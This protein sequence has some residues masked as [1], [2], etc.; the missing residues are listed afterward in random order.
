[1]LH[2]AMGSVTVRVVPRAGRTSV[3]AGTEG[4]VVRVRAAPER[5]RANEEARRA[6]AR[7]IGVPPGDVRLRS[8]ARSRD[9]V[10]EV[11]GVE[12]RDLERRL[13]GA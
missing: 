13:R 1:M 8:G 5:G 7:A 2:G 6:L 11:E 3:E 4:I 9:K 12:Q 10:F